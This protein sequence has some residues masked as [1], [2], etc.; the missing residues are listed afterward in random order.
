MSTDFDVEFDKMKK[1]LAKYVH[2]HR[3][4]RR[5]SFNFFF[6]ILGFLFLLFFNFYLGVYSYQEFN[7]FFI[8][9]LSNYFQSY[10]IENF[11][12]NFFERY[13]I[14]FNYLFIESRYPNIYDFIFVFVFFGVLGVVLYSYRR[15]ILPFFIWYVFFTIPLLFSVFYFLFFYKYFPYTVREFSILYVLLHFGINIFIAFANSFLFSLV[16]ISFGQVLFNIL[17]SAFIIIYSMI[18]GY[19]RYYV[20][21]LILNKFSY[22]YFA[23]LFFTFG[24]LLDFIYVISFYS[25]YISLILKFIY[26]DIGLWKFT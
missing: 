2:F 17:F 13:T 12:I 20:F 25:L 14:N 21:L 19:L 7:D 8:K 18:F 16:T 3:F 1:S 4:A 15:K 23:N 5:I 22:L 26:K 6:F 24:P 10:K 11:S 9:F